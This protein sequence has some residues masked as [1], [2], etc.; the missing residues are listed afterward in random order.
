MISEGVMSMIFNCVGT[1]GSFNALTALSLS[2]SLVLGSLLSLISSGDGAREFCASGF[3]CGRLCSPNWGGL[4]PPQPYLL[5][6]LPLDQMPDRFAFHLACDCL[7]ATAAPNAV[8][9]FIL[10]SSTYLT[11][12]SSSSSSCPKSN[13]Y[14][15]LQ[16][17][18]P[19]SFHLCSS[20]YCGQIP[21]IVWI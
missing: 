20:L 19:S 14:G 12:S 4:Q 8:A 9:A 10:L 6:A 11:S 15:W 7:V 18:G 17:R 2:F 16:M 13:G 21:A 1:N 3:N 5:K